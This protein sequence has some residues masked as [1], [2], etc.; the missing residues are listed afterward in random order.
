MAWFV[1]HLSQAE[2]PVAI[3]QGSMSKAVATFIII[4]AR[5]HANSQLRAKNE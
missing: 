4:I 2:F 3:I 1:K 5:P